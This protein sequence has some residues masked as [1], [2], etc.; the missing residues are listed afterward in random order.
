VAVA[1]AGSAGCGRLGFETRAGAGADG[2]VDAPG[3]AFGTCDPGAAFGIPVP[4]VELNS[5]TAE[6]TLR[7]LP[8][9]RSGYLWSDRLP[10]ERELFY[11]TRAELAAPFTITH[12]P[13]LGAPAGELD[14][15]IASDGSLLVFRRSGPGD[16]L[17]MATP[18]SPT[19]FTAPVALTALNTAAIDTQ[20]YLQP[21][22]NELL[23]SS[24][25]GGS[26]GEG[27]L[28]RSIRSGT[29]FS[30]PTRIAELATADDEGDPVLTADGLTIYFRSTRPAAF[31][32]HNIYVATRPSTADP[33][34]PAVLVDNV[35]SEGDD[36]ASW[37]SADGCRLYLSSDRSGNN[38][39]FVATRGD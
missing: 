37:L 5:A 28:Y 20:P 11:V 21:G 39:I 3:D 29:T 27:D 36:G 32:G 14:P 18:T 9:E 17:W 38:D 24:A 26:T 34:G 23:F 6:G 10:G 13:D 35:N 19:S 25:R 15:T 22:G 12:L 4:I 8:D 30:P 16:D 33:F 2:G 31:A 7:L 1:V